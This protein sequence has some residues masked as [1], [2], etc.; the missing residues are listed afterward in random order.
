MC[1]SSKPFPLFPKCVLSS[2]IERDLRQEVDVQISTPDKKTFT[3]TGATDTAIPEDYLT[4]N[5]IN[6]KVRRSKLADGRFKETTCMIA[7]ML[8]GLTSVT[9]AN[10]GD[11]LLGWISTKIIILIGTGTTPTVHSL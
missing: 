2:K 10:V 1:F 11:S 4:A 6:T 3:Y 8:D 9:V 5:D 7:V